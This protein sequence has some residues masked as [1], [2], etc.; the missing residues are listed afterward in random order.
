M[1]ISSGIPYA[2]HSGSWA[3]AETGKFRFVGQRIQPSSI[4]FEETMYALK[5]EYNRVVN[6][7][8]GYRSQAAA[9]GWFI[10]NQ[11][12][13]FSALNN[14]TS[15]AFEPNPSGANLGG[16]LSILHTTMNGDNFFATRP[17]A[18]HQKLYIDTMRE[19]ANYIFSSYGTRG[20][21]ATGATAQEDESGVRKTWLKTYKGYNDQYANSG[22][23]FLNNVDDNENSFRSGLYDRHLDEVR[24]QPLPHFGKDDGVNP[25]LLDH[26]SPWGLTRKMGHHE[27]PVIRPR[28]IMTDGSIPSGWA[29][30]IEIGRDNTTTSP[31]GL[32]GY[33]VSGI[34]FSISGTTNTYFLSGIYSG[35]MAHETR[36]DSPSYC[37]LTSIKASGSS[38]MVS[39]QYRVFLAHPN[40]S[41][42]ASFPWGTGL[43][44]H[45]AAQ[46]PWE[47]R[48]EPLNGILTSVV[49][50]YFDTNLKNQSYWVTDHMFVIQ[51]HHGGTSANPR[52]S[53]GIYWFQLNGGPSHSI[54][55]LDAW[56]QESEPAGGVVAGF[57]YQS[58]ILGLW[59][60]AGGEDVRTQYNNGSVP[61]QMMQGGGWDYDRANNYYFK[62][63]SSGLNLIDFEASG[64]YSNFNQQMVFKGGGVFPR[65]TINGNSW[66]I[67]RAYKAVE[68][69]THKWLLSAISHSG[70]TSNVLAS[71]AGFD[72][73]F[74]R[75]DSSLAIQDGLL[76]LS[77]WPVYLRSKSEYLGLLNAGPDDMH[78]GSGSRYYA[79]S[80]ISWGDLTDADATGSGSYTRTEYVMTY[81]ASTNAYLNR[82]T[83]TAIN[84]IHIGTFFE[85]EETNQVYCTLMAF[86][87]GAASGTGNIPD[88]WVA[89]VN[90]SSHP[91]NVTNVWRLG[92]AGTAYSNANDTDG[93]EL[94]DADI[95][96]IAHMQV[97]VNG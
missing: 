8:S 69:G 34:G 42:L 95:G 39:G 54:A 77:M 58:G 40:P 73:G 37:A 91:F 94:I 75:L 14:R 81:D 92:S 10:L 11:G 23:W 74:F 1:V 21:W 55:L 36:P 78:G 90:A 28:Y 4:H 76:G 5:S 53:S 13:F 46:W 19:L 47:G 97:H 80:S 82:A 56:T 22:L 79:L 61:T 88:V 2:Y 32:G 38:T 3:G 67:I 35:G 12:K 25:E 93:I 72:V 86:A 65:T 51:G 7:E 9:P 87:S 30:G 31:T 49:G 59:G 6:K 41:Q 52:L 33:L 15:G 63:G 70:S 44:T 64:I 27:W 45:S 68:D 96:N 62:V 29:S 24:L 16:K 43:T 66:G 89:K 60:L 84:R 85:T 48:Y 18:I 17:G 26:L 83:A 50:D 20:S 71:D 57:A